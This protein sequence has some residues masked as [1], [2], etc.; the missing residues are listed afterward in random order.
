MSSIL[1]PGGGLV[2]DNPGMRELHLWLA[3]DGLDDAFEDVVELAAH[4]RFSDCRHESEPGCAVQEAIA[5]GDL[6]PAR[7]ESYLGLQRELAELDEQL[8]RRERSR[9]RRGRPGARGS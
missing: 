7:L 6:D 5:R 3:E 2:V 4:C 9:A 8:V 1:L